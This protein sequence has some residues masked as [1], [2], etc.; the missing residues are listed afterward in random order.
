MSAVIV[1]FVVGLLLAPAFTL[2]YVLA[3]LLDA[4]KAIDATFAPVMYEMDMVIK[5]LSKEAS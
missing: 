1:A 3:W 5:I 4:R 2:G